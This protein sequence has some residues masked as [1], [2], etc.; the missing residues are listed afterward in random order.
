MYR[1]NSARHAQASQ[2]A[3]HCSAHDGRL[4][5]EICDNGRGFGPQ[6][7]K[8]LGHYGL[9]G[10]RERARLIGGVITI[11]S[12]AARGTRVRLSAPSAPSGGA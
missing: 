11:E 2:V 10:M 8:G 4:E 6:Q 9:L 12:T 5:L 7:E 3:I 1:P